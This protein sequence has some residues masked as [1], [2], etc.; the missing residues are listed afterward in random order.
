[1]TSPL[2][3]CILTCD[4]VGPI[5]N[6][7]I[8]TAYYNLAH[9]L[10]RDGHRVTVLYA[11]GQ[12]CENRTIAHWR[13]VYAGHGIEFV[14]LPGQDVQGHSAIKMSYA[15]YQW[16]K[17]RSF[18]IVHC[19][20]WRGVGFYTA[21]AK[22]QGLCLTDSVLC[23]GAH[24]PTLWHLEGMNELADAEALEVDF[25]ERESVARADMLWSPSAHMVAWMRR[26]GWHLPRRIVRKP[27]ILLDLPAGNTRAADPGSELVFFGRLE[28]RKG[29]D[30]FC[31]AL[32][33][34]VRRGIPPPSVTFLGKPA[35]VDG[36]PS[37]EYLKG[38]AEQW[39]FPWKIVSTLARDKAMAYLR[40]PMDVFI[41]HIK[42]GEIDARTGIKA[43]GTY[44]NW[45]THPNNPMR[46]QV[47]DGPA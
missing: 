29:L 38:R 12:F 18:D 47:E 9:A 46:K 31:D 27:Y 7:G 6:G 17:T 43:T 8:G 36:V 22:R 16:L 40:E 34:L 4:I 19:H 33:R 28:T 24:S 23:V 10:A 26:E 32:D 2:E 11:L 45:T 35:T 20:E 13:E 3:I 44:G 15:V 30:L 41:T 14:P 1:V 42:P 5:R 21:L 37:E 25:M 39:P